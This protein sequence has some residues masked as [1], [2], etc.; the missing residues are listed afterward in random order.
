LGDESQI[1]HEKHAIIISVENFEISHVING[2]ESQ[3]KI[4]SNNLLS[5]ENDTIK[6]KL[7]DSRA[8]VIKTDKELYHEKP[9]HDFKEKIHSGP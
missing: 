2:K 5:I 3:L 9:F 7:Y 8:Y 4:N 6:E 1:G